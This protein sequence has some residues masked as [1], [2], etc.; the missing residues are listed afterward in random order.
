MNHQK[1]ATTVSS[2]K[3]TSKD[4]GQII[5]GLTPEEQLEVIICFMEQDFF[6]KAAQVGECMFDSLE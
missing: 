4:I 6:D 5:E 2:L 3:N 1:V